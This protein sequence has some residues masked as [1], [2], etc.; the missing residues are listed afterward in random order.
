MRAEFSEFS[1]GFA[2]TFEVARLWSSHLVGA[3]TFPTLVQEGRSG[4]YDVA[5]KSATGFVYCA[6]FKRSEQMTRRSA[7][8]S[9][10]GYRPM[11]Y[12]RF[13]IYG[14]STSRQHQLLLDLEST[15]FLVEYVAPLF[16]R[17]RDLDRWFS[18]AALRGRVI[19]VRPSAIG[20]IPDPDDHCV[21]CDPAGGTRVLYSEP[22]ELVA[23]SDWGD[24]TE[25]GFELRSIR[26]VLD[27][28]Q[29]ISGNSSIYDQLT[30]FIQQVTDTLQVPQGR[31]E[32]LGMGLAGRA[33]A[34]ARTLL[35]AELLIMASSE[36]VNSGDD[37][38]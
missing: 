18:A 15:G 10:R 4:G 36:Q 26:D 37:P 11:P 29:S 16:V 7:L 19:R 38:T 31:F 12:F 13:P 34:V 35:G 20:V 3:P 24:I 8:E 6:Q 17:Q 1:F 27:T 32:E 9:S 33:Q 2:Y 30:G 28:G 14:S 21:A 23:P 5:L 25:D 22:R